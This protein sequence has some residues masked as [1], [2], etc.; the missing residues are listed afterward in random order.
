MSMYVLKT[1]GVEE[2]KEVEKEHLIEASGLGYAF[3]HVAQK[4]GLISGGQASSADLF[5]L[6]KAGVEVEVALPPREAQKIADAAAKAA[7][8]PKTGE[9]GKEGGGTGKTGE[10]SPEKKP[11]AEADK[12]GEGKPAK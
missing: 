11:G 9:P 7:E 1:K 10:E 5:R 2:G 3:I 6:A 12:G 8:A 4:E